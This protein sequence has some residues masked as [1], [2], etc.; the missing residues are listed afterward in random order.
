MVVHQPKQD[1]ITSADRQME[2]I[3]HFFLVAFALSALVLALSLDFALRPLGGLVKMVRSG[4][5]EQE[6]ENPRDEV[7]QVTEELKRLYSELF[8]SNQ[9][10]KES[11]EKYRLFVESAN[12][13]I[14]LTQQGKVVFINERAVK[15]SGY[16]M[17]EI[18]SSAVISF[19]HPEDREE[20][21]RRYMGIL[22]GETFPDDYEYR[23]VD[24]SGNVR[25]VWSSV[26][27][28]PAME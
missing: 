18:T 9:A 26:F 6:G 11:E 10:L 5:V 1:I 12:E 16:S 24:K 27:P 14:V 21:L 7:G 19:V 4:R 23:I 17:E 28:I 15:Q 13:G 25:W 3:S 8:R 22:Q 2:V 20:A